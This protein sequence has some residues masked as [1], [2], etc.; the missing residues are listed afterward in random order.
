MPN[1]D[2]KGPKGNG[3]KTGRGRGNC[4]KTRRKGGRK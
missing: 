1:R 2:G 4:G 3:P